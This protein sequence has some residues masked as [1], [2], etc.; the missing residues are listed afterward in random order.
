M[1]KLN[2]SGMTV[3]ITNGD[4]AGQEG[5]CLGRA[6]GTNELWAVSANS[7]N[8][9]VNLRFDDEFGVLLNP[10]QSTARN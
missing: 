3:L 10:G 6:E 9:I 4:Y 1:Q 8:Q 7:S 2:P 5:L